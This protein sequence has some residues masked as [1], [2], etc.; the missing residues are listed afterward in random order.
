MVGRREKGRSDS[1]R[2]KLVMEG[3]W[4]ESETSGAVC[5]KLG[6]GV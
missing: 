3:A 1:F 5:A 4:K 6:A 2:R